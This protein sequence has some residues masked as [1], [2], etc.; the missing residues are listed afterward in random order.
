M[1]KLFKYKLDHLLFWLL[2]VGF[3]GYTHLD[4]IERANLGQFFLEIIVRNGLL[5]LVIY[6]NL[7]VI[8]PRFVR[9]KNYWISIAGIVLSLAIYT[10]AK[11]MHDGYL[12]GTILNEPQRQAFFVNSFY[13]LSIVIF[14]LAFAV[15]LHLSKEWYLQRELLRKIEL[16]KLNTELEYL[17]AQINPHFVFNSLNTVFF[18][19]EKHNAEARETL[20]RFSDMLR[21]QLYE[22]NENEIS[23]EKEIA[24]IKNYV[25][26]Q[27]LRKNENY[28]IT[29]SSS[30]EL[31]NFTI[32][33]LLLI[34]FIENA[35][36]H[37]SHYADRK[38]E[39]EINLTKKENSFQLHVV[40]TRDSSARNESD[41]N[42]GIGL[43]NVN[44]RLELLY[45]DRYTLDV[46]ESNERYC[47][48]LTL[49]L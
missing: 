25:E 31:K 49:M 6:F 35:F 37:I 42:G 23:I 7:L 46:D 26:L 11:N 38:N 29:F 45:Q 18:Q 44:R 36:K 15:T 21:Y 3:H 32:P 20:T 22:C 34:P 1:E 39:I 4:L 13:N 47:V 24:Y 5:A 33:P 27:R 28:G 10:V 2:T 9:G 19:I 12:Y 14:Y 8:I 17:K 43:K 48:T 41:K 16:E 30:N 40:N